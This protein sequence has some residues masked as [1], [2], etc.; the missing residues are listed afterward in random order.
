MQPYSEET[1]VWGALSGDG[2]VCV[3]RR[4]ARQRYLCGADGRGEP[5]CPPGLELESDDGIAIIR[6]VLNSPKLL[7]ERIH[8]GPVPLAHLS[9]SHDQI[10]GAL[11]PVLQLSAWSKLTDASPLSLWSEISQPIE[12]RFF[13]V[14]TRSGS[15]SGLFRLVTGVKRVGLSP[16]GAPRCSVTVGLVSGASLES[17]RGERYKS[18]CP[19]L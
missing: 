19:H 16:C 3:W 1:G 6:S 5:P 18:V 4:Y 8:C 11:P 15:P 10:F 2:G 12:R 13:G 17:P 7:A 9:S 14:H